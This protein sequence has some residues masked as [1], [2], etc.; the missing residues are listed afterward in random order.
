MSAFSASVRH[1]TDNTVIGGKLLH[2]ENGL[3]IPYRQLHFDASIFGSDIQSFRFDRF[4]KDKN[5]TR[6]GS[7]GTAQCPGRF[8]AKQVVISYLA[9]RLNRFHVQLDGPQQPTRQ[10]GVGDHGE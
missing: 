3:M 1:V 8:A 9:T 2:K 5:L 7:C 6:G 4:L 10:A